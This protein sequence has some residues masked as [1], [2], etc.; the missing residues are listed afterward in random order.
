[1]RG[2]RAFALLLVSSVAV[3]KPVP[4]IKFEQFTLDNGMRVILS[5]D[6]TVPVVAQAMIFNVGGR[7]EV[8]GRSGFAHL[9]EHLMFEGSRHV[10]KGDF[11]RI[12]ETYGG[13]S[14]ASTH[15][16]FTFYYEEIP[17]HALPVALWLDADRVGGLKITRRALKN[18]VDVVKEERRMRVDNEAYGPLLY[19]DMASHT[20]ANWHNAHPTIGSYEDLS[21]AR[22]KDVRAFFKEYY[23]PKNALMA[24]VG[25]IDI[26][27]TKRWVEEYFGDIPNRAEPPEIDLSEPA[28]TAARKLS[29]LDRHAN[30]P[31]LAVSWKGM[32]ERGTRDYYALTLLGTALFSGKSSRLYQGLVKGSQAAVFADGGLGFP[33]SD[34]AEYKAPGLFGVFVIHKV[35]RTHSEVL[36]IVM[37]SIRKVAASGLKK[38]ELARIKTKFRAD[39][40]VE[41]QTNLGRARMLLVAALLDGDPGEVNRRLEKF[42]AVTSRDIRRVASNYLTEETATVFEVAAGGAK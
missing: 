10:R 17:S 13:D 18:Q 35:G 20:F 36:N 22:L 15:M 37:K 39:W 31:A 9:F 19:V 7:Q 24:I 40:I 4:P 32:P 25:D 42:M 23:A 34:F 33:V 6:S 30:L 29:F 41:R 14:N 38:R 27:R 3:A 26:A 2:F 8:P 12:L 21:A 1:M 5:R 11:D 28:P 16:D